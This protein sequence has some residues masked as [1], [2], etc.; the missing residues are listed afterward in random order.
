MKPMKPP[1]L[2]ILMQIPGLLG[3]GLVLWGLTAYE[4]ISHT[5]ALLQVVAWLVKDAALYPFV[6]RAFEPTRPGDSGPAGLIGGIGTTT[7]ELAPNGFVRIRGELW[8]ARP[9]DAAAFIPVQRTVQVVAAQGM[10]LVV[11]EMENER[12]DPAANIGESVSG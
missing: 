6:K 10:V 3:L 1:L 7:R 5:T 11:R 4:W 9:V 12:S 8:Q 2:Y